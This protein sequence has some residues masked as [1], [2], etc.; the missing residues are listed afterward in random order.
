[1]ADK[2]YRR[3]LTDFQPDPQNA[4]KHSQRG[5]SALETSLRTYG[6]GRSILVDKNGK[7]IGGNG[8][9]E[10]AIDIGLTDA[11]VVPSD[12]KQV[13]VVQRVDIDLDS[14]AG[15]EMALAD[16]RVAEMNL[17]W[18]A[19]A[20]KALADAGEVDLAQFWH[21]DELAALLAN[22]DGG[23]GATDPGPQIDRAGE[24]QEKWQTAV[25]Q[26]WQV[27]RH[28][29][30]VGSC[31]DGAVVSALLQGEKADAC[32][33]DPPYNVGIDYNNNLSDQQDYSAYKTFSA[34]WFGLARDNSTVLLFTPGRG[35]ALVNL[36]MWFEIERPIDMAVWVKKNS[37]THGSLSHFMAWEAIL[38]YGTPPRR[39][40]QD[41]YDYPIANQFSEGVA[42]TDYHPTPKLLELW[43]NL[44]ED[45]TDNRGVVYEPFS[46][47]GTTLVACEQTGRIGR[48]IEIEPKYCAVTLERLAAMGLE[49]R[50]L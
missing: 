7:V 24:L 16:N 48:G 20:L 2:V 46:G 5:M 36:H 39:I 50:R 19:D 40:S 12:G 29:I 37:T 49:A 22:V 14:K 18:D 10:T 42:L 11:L 1:M 34:S 15:R 3:K 6:A 38:V 26:I 9:Q 28:R 30:A 43:K 21:E 41:V 47:S 25:G 4:N 31:T 33:T 45:F 35:H 27:G 32:V 44:I 8:V 23:T 17:T 13:V